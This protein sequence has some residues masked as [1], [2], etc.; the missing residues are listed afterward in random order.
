VLIIRPKNLLSTF[1]Y[2]Q[3][4]RKSY[5][6]LKKLI[7][8]ETERI[9]LVPDN[10]NIRNTLFICDECFSKGFGAFF[11]QMDRLVGRVGLEPTQPLGRR[12]L[13][14]LRLP[15]PPPPRAFYF[16]ASRSSVNIQ[17]ESHFISCDFCTAFF[18]YA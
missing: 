9:F 12:I 16:N 1:V 18:I 17:R 13:S 10:K 4:T 8:L 5:S 14:P 15:I 2:F 6:H 3:S 7:N 11:I